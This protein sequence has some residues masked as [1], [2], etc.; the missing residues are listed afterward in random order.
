MKLI[1]CSLKVGHFWPNI[2]GSLLSGL[3][4]GIKLGHPSQ[5]MV[6]VIKTYL[7]KDQR[8]LFSSQELI[9]F[10]SRVDAFVIVFVL[11]SGQSDQSVCFRQRCAYLFGSFLQPIDYC[12]IYLFQ[13]M[14][15]GRV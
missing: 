3:K 8:L 4:F 11:I 9:L 1:C 13:G 7:A 10:F 6:T 15:I 5:N 2:I 14:V 12:T